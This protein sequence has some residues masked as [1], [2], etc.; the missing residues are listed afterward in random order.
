[1]RGLALTSPSSTVG[2]KARHARKSY[3]VRLARRSADGDDEAYRY[4]VMS[5]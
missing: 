2:V 1:M 3:G 5:S 4:L